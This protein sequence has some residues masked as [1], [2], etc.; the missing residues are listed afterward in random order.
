MITDLRRLGMRFR[1][2]AVG[3]AVCAVLGGYAASPALSAD[4]PDQQQVVDKAKMT[5]DSFGEDEGMKAALKE[6]GKESK[7]LFIIPQFMRG[8]F[9][10]GGAG[11]S[12]V[13]IVRD[14]KSGKWS[15]PVFYNIGSASFGLQIGADVSEMV[16][17]VRTQK[18]LE[19][20]YTN[21]FK[22]GANAGMAVG[23]VGAG[24]AAK[25]I[26]ADIVSYAKKKGAFAGIAL[27]GSGVTV[28]NDSNKAYYGREVRPTDVI[29]KKEVGNPKSLKLR[30]SAEKLMK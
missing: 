22:L 11:G 26:S 7:A 16:L 29:V 27:D 21:D 12:G 4:A 10:F 25:G 2:A 18:G 20:F 6:L 5:L 24:I 23:P 15:D 19:E 14:E 13:L 8:A 17:V 9:I 3:M 30:E 1:A 28:S